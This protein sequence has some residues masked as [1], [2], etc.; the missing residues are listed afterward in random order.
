MRYLQAIHLGLVPFIAATLALTGCGRVV[1]GADELPGASTPRMVSLV[2]QRPTLPSGVYVA[3][4]TITPDKSQI[5]VGEQRRFAVTI[6]GSD[7]KAYTDPRLVTWALSDPTAGAIDDQGIFTP[8]VQRVVTVRAMIQDRSAQATVTITP[9]VYTW[10]QVQSPTNADL[11]GV[12]MISSKEAW[13]VGAQ[14]TVLHFLNGT[15]QNMNYPIPQTSTWRSIDFCNPGSGWVVGHQG[16]DETSTAP[17]IALAYRGGN[18]VPTETGVSGALLGVSVVAANDAWAVGRDDKGD[19]LLLHWTGSAWTR[20]TSFTCKGQLNA[21]QMLGG[22]DG[23]AVG[24]EGRGALVLHYDGKSWKRSKL[25]AFFASFS[26]SEFKGLQ[27]L[28]G[29]QGFAVGQKTDALGVTTGLMMQYDG[30]S[31]SMVNFSNWSEKKA[32]SGATKYLDQVP[33]RGISMLDPDKGWLL[34]SVVTPKRIEDPKSWFNGSVNDVYGNL[35][36]FNGVSYDIDNNF[37]HYNL[38][39]DFMGINVLPEGDGC[40]VGRSGYIMQRAYDWR[41]FNTSNPFS[42]TPGVNQ[43]PAPAY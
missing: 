33:L 30:R 23:W 16:V 7:G 11:Y 4:L 2:N 14:G 17:A 21:V 15:W 31:S 38:S 13:A 40:I 29:Q 6:A 18:W 25:P 19:A 41:G 20:D 27:M 12:E 39:N 35:L 5:A 24:K 37:H 3:S 8:Q 32:A 10:Q 42:T 36:G 28:N 34:G 9:A 22:S 1:T 26:A 43:T